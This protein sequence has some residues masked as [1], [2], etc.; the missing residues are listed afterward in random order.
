M[1]FAAIAAFATAATAASSA[2]SSVAAYWGQSGG[3]LRTYCETTDLDYIPLGFISLFPA[4]ANGWP[5][6]NYAS[7]CWA[8]YYD[9]PGYHGVD[10]NTNNLLLSHCPGMAQDIQYCQSQGKKILLS[11]G[12]GTPEYNLT[13]KVDGEAFADFLWG[14]YGPLTDAWAGLPRPF[15]PLPGTEGE[16]IPTIVD[17]FDF[18]IEHP[19]S[20]NSVGYIAMINRLRSYFPVG[21]NYII[22]GAPQCEVNDA[23]MDLMIQ[24]AQFD[25]LFVQYYN[26]DGCSVRDWIKL[27]PNYAKTG[28]ETT[29]PAGYKFGGFSYNQ[30]LK[31]IQASGSKSKNA[32]LAIGIPGDAPEAGVVDYR[33]TADELKPLIDAYYCH[34]NFGGFMLWDAVSA[35]NN[36]KNGVTFQAQIKNLLN[37]REAQGCPGGPVTSTTSGTASPTTMATS[38]RT[39]S[40]TTTTSQPP[41]S[42]TIDGTAYPNPPAPTV[43][44][45]TPK[46][47]QWYVV[48]SGDSCP[49]IATK[50]DVTKTEINLWNTYINTACSNIWADY[51]VCVSSPIKEEY[52]TSVGCFTDS[53][54]ARA[55]AVRMTLPNEKTV[56]TPKLCTDACYA[57]GYRLSGL[58][59]GSQCWCDSAVRNNQA[60][61][62][63]GCTMACPGVPGVMCGGSDRMNLYR[64]ESYK[65]MGCYSDV[66]TSRTLEKQIIITN[67]NTILTREICQVACEKAGYVYSGVEYAHQCWCGYGV[68]GSPAAGCSS[69]CPGNTAELCGGSD[70]INIMMKPQSRSLGCYSDDVNKRTL[71]YQQTITNAATLMTPELCRTTCLTNGFIYSGVEYGHQCFCDDELYGTGAPATGCTMACPGNSGAVCGGSSRISIY[72]L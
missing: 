70:R 36:L 22:T 42:T 39:T 1:K 9:A 18:D 16:G 66:T 65:D 29:V 58:E 5:G 24:G 62:S 19:D 41:S 7:S 60:L 32:K 15:D 30:W 61:T 51:A 33:V 27:N 25:I 64:L 28:V 50:F 63:A 57:A 43:T 52:W 49:G 17:G 45:S 8:E 68:F 10:N 55:L 35:G 26:T 71:R 69:A 37:A 40:A 11:L 3:T 23:N 54:T 13:G 72:S 56:M 6:S 31:R 67:Q 47:K 53:Q 2:R 21:S 44:G 14:A 20:D 34:D 38:T 59:Y 4:Q 12:G 48:K 46:C